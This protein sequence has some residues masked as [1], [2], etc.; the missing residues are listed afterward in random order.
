MNFDLSAVDDLLRHESDAPTIGLILCK[1]RDHVTVECAL[2]NTVAPIGVAEFRVTDA[3]P[4]DLAESL[5]SVRDVEAELADGAELG[6]GGE[7][8]PS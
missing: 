1:A 6:D 3:L 2:R 7:D 5:P 4:A 8:M